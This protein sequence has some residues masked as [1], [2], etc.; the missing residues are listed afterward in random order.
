VG[1]SGGRNDPNKDLPNAL[2]AARDIMLASLAHTPPKLILDTSTSDD[3]GY[4]KF[5]TSLVPQLDSMIHA[6]YVKIA[7]VDGVTI[8]QRT[9]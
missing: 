4:S 1:R 3:L 9:A 2:P 5:P 6:D 7:V 8:W